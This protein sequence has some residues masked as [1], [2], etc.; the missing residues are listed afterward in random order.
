M[1]MSKDLGAGRPTR[2]KIDS[3]YVRR[4][5]GPQR[6]ERAYRILLGSEAAANEPHLGRPGKTGPGPE[7]R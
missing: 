1:D 5:D 2:W 3:V 7:K 6:I 4:R